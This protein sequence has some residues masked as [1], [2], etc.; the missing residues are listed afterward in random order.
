M[1]T[2]T[3]ITSAERAVEIRNHLRQVL[4]LPVS[5]FVIAFETDAGDQGV[6]YTSPNALRVLDPR[7]IAEEVSCRSVAEARKIIRPA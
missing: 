1:N 7:A 2:E 4:G 5:H 3:Y 6:I